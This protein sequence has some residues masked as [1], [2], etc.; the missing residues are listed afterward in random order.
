MF[1]RKNF[2]G[3]TYQNVKKLYKR[4]FFTPAGMRRYFAKIGAGKHC[5]VCGATCGSFL[6]SKNSLRVTKE[7]D[8][9]SCK[10]LLQAV[11]P[12]CECCARL[13][14]LWLLWEQTGFFKRLPD[15]VILHFAPERAA[16]I[17]LQAAA[18][19]YHACD[20]DVSH[21][22]HITSITQQDI[23]ALTY[24]D[25]QFDALICSHVLEHIIDDA[26]AMRNLHRVLKKGG[27]AYLLVPIGKKLTHT[28]EDSSITKPEDREE[29]FGQF[30]H[31]RIYA[32]ADFIARLEKAGFKV[33]PS[34]PKMTEEE[35]VRYGC[36][37]KDEEIF[38]CEKV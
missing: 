15:L 1:L 14:V 38:V 10:S 28:K 30:D 20:I 32:R 3:S 27:K 2:S 19:E 21:Y 25:E 11:C 34:R 33:T 35:M 29:A 6:P 12:Q 7:A 23:T 31:V 17:N 16:S 24:A 18:K 5:V 36:E 9:I 26:L 13:R 8:I 4:C 37:D 22:K